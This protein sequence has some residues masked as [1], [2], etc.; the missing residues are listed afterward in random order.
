MS[1]R[2]WRDTGSY[3]ILKE[4]HG[5]DRESMA[6]HPTCGK[7]NRETEKERKCVTLRWGMIVTYHIKN[8]TRKLHK[9]EK[10]A[11]YGMGN[12]KTE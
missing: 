3:K 1:Q 5:Q 4:I 8:V 9:K 12:A 10:I 2:K 6:I 7:C 11:S